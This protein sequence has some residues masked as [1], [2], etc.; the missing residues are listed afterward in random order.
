MNDLKTK[1]KI[2]RQLGLDGRD[3]KT[4]LVE[5]K[6][7][8]QYAMKKFK[9][10]KSEK[11]IADEVL[12]QRV[13]SN[14]FISPKIVDVDLRKKFIV[15]EKMDFHLLDEINAKNG[16][17]SKKRQHELVRILKK[18]DKLKI[19]HGDVNILNFM[20]KN[21]KLFVI[22]FGMSKKITDTLIKKVGT[23]HPNLRLV[24]LSFI[25]KLAEAGVNANSISYLQS[26][27]NN[28]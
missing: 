10:N 13:C 17:F 7:G 19:F 9:K 23:T 26:Q 8:C 11:K 15:M 28:S 5:D 21:G 25:T 6:F 18:M 2:G 12:F 14:V 4:F 16:I 20:I 22:D 24:L 27:L 3:G 1:Y